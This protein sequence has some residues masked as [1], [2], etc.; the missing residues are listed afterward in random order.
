MTININPELLKAGE[1]RGQKRSAELMKAL[2]AGEER[3]KIRA[4][5]NSPSA[6]GA[7]PQKAQTP[8]N[9]IKMGEGGAN[10][11]QTQQMSAR[12]TPQEERGLFAKWL[13]RRKASELGQ[14]YMPEVTAEDKINSQMQQLRQ[15]NAQAALLAAA[16]AAQTVSG[17]LQEYGAA[18]RERVLQNNPELSNEGYNARIKQAV[19]AAVTPGQQKS[20]QLYAKESELI[21]KYLN[22]R[23]AEERQT[24]EWELKTLR[25]YLPG[26][27]K[28]M[29]RV[30]GAVGGGIA[31]ME[32]GVAKA[33]NPLGE[34]KAEEVMRNVA[35]ADVK[36]KE[37][38]NGIGRLAYDAA[39]T[40]TGNLAA[41]AVAGATGGA[42]NPLLTMGAAAAGQGVQKAKQQGASDQQALLSGLV[43]GTVEAAFEKLPLDNLY[44]LYGKGA[45]GVISGNAAVY[46]AAVAKQ[47]GI[48]GSTEM[49]TTYAQNLADLA[50]WE[51]EQNPELNMNEWLAATLKEMAYSGVLGAVVGG[52]MGAPAAVMNVNADMQAQKNAPASVAETKEEQTPT[53]AENQAET[54]ANAPLVG[55][56]T[57]PLRVGKATVIKKPY[58]GVTPQNVNGAPAPQKTAEIGQAAL[59]AAQQMIN[60]AREDG[61]FASTMKGILRTVFSHNG[62]QRAVRLQN[63]H[64]DNAPY[65]A[66]VNK[67]VADKVA[68][69]PNMTAEKLAVFQQLDEVLS[70][71]EFVGSGEYGKGNV[72]KASRVIRYD[73]FE[74]EVAVAGQP[75]VITFDVE[76][77]KD[78]NNLRTY[79]V[80]NEMS[81]QPLT[82][83]P[84]P[85]PGA[86]NGEGSFANNS[87]AN[88]LAKSNGKAEEFGGQ[89]EDETVAVPAARAEEWSKAEKVAAALG[90]K[91]APME[92]LADGEYADGV[93]RLNVN[94]EQP[95]MKLLVHELTHHIENSGYY[96][97]LADY[98]E[99]YISGTMKL[100]AKAMQ[101][102][103]AAEYAA[104]GVELDE[105]GARRELVAK[106]CEQK[107]FGDEAAIERLANT[108]RSLFERIYEWVQDM[109]VR[110]R[111]TAAEAELR[112]IEK[113]Y[114]KAAQSTGSTDRIDK[115]KAAEVVLPSKNISVTETIGRTSAADDSITDSG[116]ESNSR[117][118][119]NVGKVQYSINPDFARQI[120]EWDGQSYVAFNM[121][122]TSDVLQSIGVDSRKIIWHSNKIAQILSKHIG[123][124]R[125]IIK[126]VPEIL[127]NPIAVLKSQQ[128]ESRIAIFGEVRDANNAPVLAVLELEPAKQNGRLLN[129][130][131]VASAYGKDS[132]PAGFIRNSE[133][134]YLDS[135]KNRTDKWLQ[136]FRL[137]LPSG[138]TTYGS[139]GSITYQDGKVKI[140]G[141]PYSQ[142]MQNG[143]ENT[144]KNSQK[145]LG[146]SFDEL[147]KQQRAAA[148]EEAEML[149]AE[150][151]EK[152]K[153]KISAEAVKNEVYRE[154]WAGYDRNEFE[155]AIL[156]LYGVPKGSRGEARNLIKEFAKRMT[157]N[158]LVSG[159]DC[160]ELSCALYELGG[161]EDNGYAQANPGLKEQMLGYQI[162]V[163][164]DVRANI[165]DFDNIRKR[166]RLNLRTTHKQSPFSIL[167]IDDVYDELQAEYGAA[168]F[169]DQDN[170]TAKLQQ[171]LAVRDRLE[172][173]FESWTEMDERLGADSHGYLL[174]ELKREAAEYVKLRLQKLAEKNQNEADG[175]PKDIA[176]VKE[177]LNEEESKNADV[178]AREFLW[179]REMTSPTMGLTL[180]NKDL[181]RA[182]DKLAGDN[183]ELRKTMG[184]LIER[185]L[186]E[187]KRQRAM[188]EQQLLDDLY[189]KM[190]ELGIKA[191]S[192]E[193]AAVQ[194]FGEGRRLATKADGKLPYTQKDFDEDMK[195]LGEVKLDSTYAKAKVAKLKR[196]YKKWLADG[197]RPYKG[198]ETVP[199][200]LADLQ[201]EFP[202]KWQKIVE[203]SEYIRGVYDE[204]FDS[205]NETLQR[206]Y[207]HSAE[208][209]QQQVAAKLASRDRCKQR[210]ERL[211][212]DIATNRERLERAEQEYARYEMRGLQEKAKRTAAVIRMLK[213]TTEN[214]QQQL[215]NSL[216]AADRYESMAM[217][218]HH[219]YESGDAQRRHR[220]T[221][222][223]NYFHH[224]NEEG[225]LHNL[226]QAIIE[227]AEIDSK[228]A[229]ISADTKPNSRFWGAMEQR[230]GARY[231][232]DAVGGLLRY[233]PAACNK[234]YIDPYIAGGRKIVKGVAEA[235]EDTRNANG[236]LKWYT[237]FL[238]NLAGKSHPVDRI[239]TDQAN[240][241]VVRIARVANSQVRRN[242]ICGNLGSFVAQWFNL[243]NAMFYIGSPKAWAGA[244]K[245]LAEY[246]FKQGSAR[247][248]QDM[249]GFLTERFMDRKISRFNT[250]AMAVPGRFAE[251]LLTFG[252]EMVSRL[253]WFAALRQKQR[254]LLGDEQTRL[255]PVAYA[256]EITRRCV[257]G[258]GVGEVPLNQQAELMKMVAPFQLE[259]NN[260]WQLM[261]EML[262]GKELSGRQKAGAWARMMLLMFVMNSLAEYLR[263]SGVGF[264][265]LGAVVDVV[266]DAVNGADDE[267]E[268]TLAGRAQQL[269]LRLMGET[270]SAM[271][272]G[273]EVT[274]A[275]F[276]EESDRQK[277]FGEAD[278]TRFGTGS[279]LGQKLGAF[280]FDIATGEDVS[281]SGFALATSLLMPGYGGQLGKTLGTLQDMGWA[282]KVT[283]GIKDGFKF[284][285]EKGSFSDS[286]RYRFSIDTDNLMNVDTLTNVA[287]GLA[288]GRWGTAEAQAYIEDG[289]NPLSEKVTEAARSFRD[290]YGME[291]AD[292]AAIYKAARDVK[293]DKDKKG[294]S[295]Q[296]G[297]AKEQKGEGKSASL[298]KK[299]LIDR[300]AKDI[301]QRGKQQLY[302]DMG[303]SEKVW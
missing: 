166:R 86:A 220:M 49:L 90:V 75:Y 293:G 249:S 141:T 34:G 46:L 153:E 198:N 162:Y 299:Q 108:E 206:I 29:S 185:P 122:R 232:E 118:M 295:I 127:E 6:K 26:S 36:G 180:Y 256:D 155:N 235:T 95:L 68:S 62:G 276:T 174:T 269:G 18:R 175:S 196:E 24:A 178:D 197:K 288:L 187:L 280:A 195:Q 169:P 12:T 221:K 211:A 158:N 144:G 15:E 135:N 69:D 56:D 285:V 150:A 103:L 116:Q 199:Y 134:L 107:L 123:M 152:V 85:Q 159:R 84:G 240:R 63:V 261:K 87:I 210:A 105:D 275:I 228:L 193:S 279:L 16:K 214:M 172:P 241:K 96:A 54:G 229:A 72:G 282:P 204:L 9:V 128:A 291:L 130:N 192:K 176:I 216:T 52:A 80:I 81:L 194:K 278:P 42:V 65:E 264:D 82:A 142:L 140:V 253:I 50:I 163:P 121:G 148:R 289:M 19:D 28:R 77:Y 161:K 59:D 100:D 99:R 132:N 120:D 224:Y 154:N 168:S 267:E 259:V 262:V 104:G 263:G 273:A 30:Q 110:L 268:I 33:L 13:E 266:M 57:E 66:M 53:A 20:M 254:V 303:V 112:R 27:Y 265:P 39:Q 255:D 215:E 38:L 136:S 74:N 98:V 131:V 234:I 190:G 14:N 171:L 201:R 170:Q 125:E 284:D 191:G 44:K 25:G 91:L 48:E 64:F 160:Y 227:P 119:Q 205:T 156:R 257:G 37:G 114:I 277:R 88:S 83:T 10:A 248:L 226:W 92:G 200:T 101:R 8:V 222:R 212:E 40:V 250:G 167:S 297:S 283:L 246:L 183:A 164:A 271:P 71:A 124:T 202:D 184:A 58:A 47:A 70:G 45:K 188:H 147:A 5:A 3:G 189:V 244:F 97:A 270:L 186:L 243:P 67:S 298:K 102:D 208:E 252:D 94:S 23:T 231:R 157:V 41:L 60:E 137:Q 230:K 11:P 251:W 89:S 78:T 61:H 247:E 274:A 109:L 73:Y 4:A 129:L 300:M 286:G 17:K 223:A 138:D 151:A 7:E 55:Q 281:D 79:K 294:N 258:R 225:A 236:F 32:A 302:V 203:A 218:L 2:K 106:F 292:Y 233:I 173:S 207:P 209:I 117:L 133:V 31:G 260:Q 149:A 21:Q 290:E 165:E 237:E 93:V 301:G 146:S 143:G 239:L 43:Q 115:K 35:A 181:G 213:K 76:V 1:K 182:L 179:A 217:H 177:L 139:M 111:G 219:L 51:K 113:L 287:K 238:N 245:D 22:A 272:M 126:Q 242:M 296:P 145:S